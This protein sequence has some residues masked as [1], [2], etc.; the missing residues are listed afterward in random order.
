MSAASEPVVI[1]ESADPNELRL[2]RN[3]LESAGIPCQVESDGASSFLGAALGSH[4]TGFHRLCV[5]SEAAERAG[6]VLEEAW[7]DRAPEE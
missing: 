5:P 3:L 4:F 7:L 2:A 6:E 1:F